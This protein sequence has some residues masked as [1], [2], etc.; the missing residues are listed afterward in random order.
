MGVG[1][2][3][4]THTTLNMRRGLARC[5]HRNLTA[6]CVT[7]LNCGHMALSHNNKQPWLPYQIVTTSQNMFNAKVITVT[8]PQ[9]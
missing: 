2:P 7:T 9:R 4:V 3:T 6:L 5:H 8:S 1:P